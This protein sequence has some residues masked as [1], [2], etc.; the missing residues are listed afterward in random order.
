MST[1]I[2]VGSTGR[3]G[4]PTRPDLVGIPSEKFK[5]FGVRYELFHLLGFEF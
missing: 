3:V 1:K 2:H 4:Y 5:W